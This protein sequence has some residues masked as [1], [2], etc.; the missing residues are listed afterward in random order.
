MRRVLRESAVVG[1]VAGHDAVDGIDADTFVRGSSACY[2]V[3]GLAHHSSSCAA[4][5]DVLGCT[6]RMEYAQVNVRRVIDSERVCRY[7]SL[8]DHC[9]RATGFEEGALCGDFVGCAE[10]NS[11]ARLQAAGTGKDHLPSND[12]DGTE[13]EPVRQPVMSD[14]NDGVAS[15]CRGSGNKKVVFVVDVSSTWT[16]R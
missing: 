8:P 1:D 13:R 6:S 12:A 4:P 7:C 9:S 3:D 15:F 10:G 5:A 2:T 14:L 11:I 16:C